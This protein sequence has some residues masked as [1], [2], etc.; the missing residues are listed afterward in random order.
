[1]ATPIINPD[2]LQR[3]TEF[4]LFLCHCRCCGQDETCVDDC[5]FETDTP[6][7]NAQMMAARRALFGEES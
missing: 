7:E 4:V 2:R 1:M 5:T 6:A 3:L